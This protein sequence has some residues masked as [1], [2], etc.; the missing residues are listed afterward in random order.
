MSAINKTK[1]ANAEKHRDLSDIGI[2]ALRSDERQ[3]RRKRFEELK[4]E[5]KKYSVLG[6]DTDGKRKT[7]YTPEQFAI[8]I[9]QG[10]FEINSMI[11]EI[12]SPFGGAGSTEWFAEA[13]LGWSQIYGQVAS[14][15][16][17]LLSC[18]DLKNQESNKYY[19]EDENSTLEKIH[20]TATMKDVYKILA[21]KNPVTLTKNLIDEHL[22][23]SSKMSLVR[24]FFTFYQV[25]YLP[26]AQFMH[27][28][29]WDKEQE[30]WAVTVYQPPAMPMGRQ[31][32]GLGD[33]A[34]PNETQTY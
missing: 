28:L 4:K 12:G 33:L 30:Y 17:T 22:L 31:G 16:E 21:R 5:I 1:E 9:Q 32:E 24:S 15:A 6:I 34:N 25:E 29:C 18:L 13:R 10:I 26:W 7:D 14:M 20:G 27:D 19:S 11:N 3:K 8:D 23:N 2:N